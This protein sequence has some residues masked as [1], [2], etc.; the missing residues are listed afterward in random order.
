MSTTPSQSISTTVPR[1]S[2][3]SLSRSLHKNFYFIMSLV[4]AAVVID[5]FSRTVSSDL[6]HA[7]PLR[8]FVLWLH[9][10]VF[11]GWVLFFILQTALI[12]TRNVKIHRT[13]GWFGV[14]I[15]CGI[16]ILGITT[17]VTMDRFRSAVL[18]Q[19]DA[20]KFA[21]VPFNDMLCFTVPFFLAVYW[22]KKP[23]YHRRLMFIASCA[24]TAAAFGRIPFFVHSLTFYLG[25]DALIVCGILRDIVADGKVSVIYRYA[26]PAIAA[27]QAFAVYTYVAYPPY[28]Q[29]AS[30]L[31]AP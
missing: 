1:A 19:S 20:A 9:A 12:R 3:F 18:H 10:T 14:A 24:L 8:P 29:A 5:G 2:S 21:I 31:I 30:H 13:L 6:F 22:R 4:I 23:D 28:W 27:V 25:V 11:F 17:A 15:G 7:V 16:P 26:L